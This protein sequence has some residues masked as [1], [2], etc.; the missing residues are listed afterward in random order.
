MGAKHG[1]TVVDSIPVA[2][3]KSSPLATE[4][5]FGLP[6]ASCVHESAEP[7]PF[8]D[9]ECIFPCLHA[10][11]VRL[12]FSVSGRRNTT[13]RPSMADCPSTTDCL[14]TTDCPSAVD[15]RFGGHGSY[16][17]HRQRASWVSVKVF[18]SNSGSFRW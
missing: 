18:P 10:F 11:C 14:S 12:L 3:R 8:L 15:R 9:T 2:V 16:F 17:M 4:C 13:G 5:D 6:G 1:M 7:P